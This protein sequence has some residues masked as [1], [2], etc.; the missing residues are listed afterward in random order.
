MK[1]MKSCTFDEL[2]VD[3]LKTDS[4]YRKITVCKLKYLAR[5]LHVQE[6]A[7]FAMFVLFGFDS[8]KF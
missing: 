1:A 8:I 7:E 2:E 3:R 5:I 4:D 6:P